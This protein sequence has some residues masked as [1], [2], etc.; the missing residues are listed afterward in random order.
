MD[1]HVNLVRSGVD[2]LREGR[3]VEQPQAVRRHRSKHDASEAA[4]AAAA[5]PKDRL[6][7]PILVAT[8]EAQTKSR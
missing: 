6:A 5:R 8:L 4:K 1:G 3:R 7:L 2:E